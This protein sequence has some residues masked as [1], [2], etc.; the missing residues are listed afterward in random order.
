M[1]L[2]V[3]LVKSE[4][5]AVST[6]FQPGNILTVR[7]CRF[8]DFGLRRISPDPGLAR[9]PP[10]LDRA[11]DDARKPAVQLISSTSTSMAM[12]AKAPVLR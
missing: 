7:P 11:D 2:E 12:T 9:E 10:R 3:V 1:T 5:V 8:G 6:Q 4:N